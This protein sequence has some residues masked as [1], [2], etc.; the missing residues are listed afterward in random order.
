MSNHRKQ[1]KLRARHTAKS[2]V[3]EGNAIVAELETLCTQIDDLRSTV[4]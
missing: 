2:L 3:K 1:K 4:L